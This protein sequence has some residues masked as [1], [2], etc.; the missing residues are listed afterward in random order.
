[1]AEP[2]EFEF[3][4]GGD[5]RVFIYHRGRLA[6]TLNGRPAVDFLLKV[7]RSDAAGAQLLMAKATGNYKRGN[8]RAAKKR[9][10]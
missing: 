1:M 10:S 2:S 6:E 7:E 9:R 5:E 8:E 3:Q 4:T